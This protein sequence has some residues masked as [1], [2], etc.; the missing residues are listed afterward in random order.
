MMMV[1][2]GR[3]ED[4]RSCRQVCKSW[5]LMISQMTDSSKK[6]IKNN[7]AS[8][9]D[10]IKNQWVQ[11]TPLLP[12]ITNAASLAH[13]GLLFS[14]EDMWLEDVDLASVKA[15]HL[16][17]LASIVSRTI[18]IKDVR[19]CDLSHL[20][21]PACCGRLGICQSLSRGETRALLQAMEHGVK[22]V[23]IWDV[24]GDL[25]LDLDL[26]IETLSLYN[27]QG[28]CLSVM[29]G[30]VIDI[31]TVH[32][33]DWAIKVNWKVETNENEDEVIFFR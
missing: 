9:A 26:D 27:G 12:E 30:H 25:D 15:E 21:G 7:A 22:T 19:N 6:I 2:L 14:V 23:E 1:G 4:L 33:M 29:C 8:E 5:Y 16:A 3:L 31:Y 11:H 18:N 13:H 32:L 17:S 28:K 24:G 20:L 10:E